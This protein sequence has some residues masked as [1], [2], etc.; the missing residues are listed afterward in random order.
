MGHLAFL[1]ANKVNGV[2]ALHGDLMKTTVF[3]ALNRHYPDRITAV[4]NGV[5]PRRWI[6]TANPGLAG[7]LDEVLGQGWI[8][9]L[10]QLAG[11]RAH[12]DDKALHEKLAIVRRDNKVKLSSIV[13]RL[14]GPALDPDALFDIQIKRI[15]EYKR[16]LLNILEAIA[17]WQRSR[18]RADW[19]MPRPG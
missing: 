10:D 8:T 7:I 16:Q 15:H 12:L 13:A 3:R 18:R 6:L 1:G 9:D 4:T 19:S 2:S 17:R 11:L 5:T 14:A